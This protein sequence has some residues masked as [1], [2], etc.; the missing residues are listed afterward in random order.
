MSITF[1]QDQFAKLTQ[2]LDVMRQ[3]LDLIST[4]TLGPDALNQVDHAGVA[5][6]GQSPA[7]DRDFE[8]TMTASP[9]V[10]GRPIPWGQQCLALHPDFIDG[11]LW[12]ESKI[13]LK[14]EIL[15]P[16]MKF[17]SNINPKTRNPKSTASGL[18]QFMAGTAKNL[19]TTI[20]KIRAMD[21]MAQL[22]YVYKYFADQ[23]EDWTGMNVDDVYMAILWPLAVGKSSDYVLWDSKDG[24]YVVNKGLDWNKDGKITKAEACKRVRELQKEGYEDGN[25]LYQHNEIL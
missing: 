10:P 2:G 5:G 6:A 13:A 9:G 1:S 11:L 19:G 3:G 12:I 8:E 4:V 14:P 22:S 23:R 25:V 21:A 15:V 16:C 17:E 20:E 7:I 18:I 24:A